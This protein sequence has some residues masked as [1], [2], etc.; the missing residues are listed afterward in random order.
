M[1]SKLT[2]KGPIALYISY[3]VL[4]ALSLSLVALSFRV[5]SLSDLFLQL[6]VTGIGTALISLSLILYYTQ[7]ERKI[8]PH[9]WR[10][11]ANTYYNDEGIF[12]YTHDGF[13]VITKEGKSL[14]VP[15]KD[16]LR[17]DSGESKLNDHIKK[18]HIDLY[19]SERDFI[20]VDSTM[21]GFSLFEKRLKE[22]LRTLFEKETQP[23]NN[24]GTD[25]IKH[26]AKIS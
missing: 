8:I 22:N 17:A 16:I 25:S 19:F 21:P 4:L 3:Y 15:W 9:Q 24:K 2:Y 5:D 20:T 26:P 1:K 6:L 11:S 14:G 7:I 18:F 12:E 10:K 13:V 23:S